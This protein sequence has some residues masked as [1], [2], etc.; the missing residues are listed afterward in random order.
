MCSPFADLGTLL[1]AKLYADLGKIWEKAGKNAA[2]RKMCVPAVAGC[3][4]GLWRLFARG[5]LRTCCARARN[6][7]RLRSEHVASKSAAQLPQKPVKQGER[8]LHVL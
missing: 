5:L 2:W 1:T 6:V 8:R 7:L 3:L 4:H